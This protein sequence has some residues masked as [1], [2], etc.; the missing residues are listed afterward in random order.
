MWR[1]CLWGYYEC[2]DQFGSPGNS[3]ISGSPYLGACRFFSLLS[4]YT[5]RYLN[6]NAHRHPC[7]LLEWNPQTQCSSG[8][9]QFMPGDSPD[10]YSGDVWS[11]TSWGCRLSSDLSGYLKLCHGRFLPHPF[12]LF[13]NRLLPFDT[14][15]TELLSSSLRTFL[16]LIKHRKHNSKQSE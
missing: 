6:T 11:V 16:C 2:D 1:K 12:Q 14:V 8:R 10:Q 4:F 13:T 15:Y 7:L 9:R 3:C 5:G